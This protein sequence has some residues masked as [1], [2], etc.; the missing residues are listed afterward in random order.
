MSKMR[1]SHYKRSLLTPPL[2]AVWLSEETVRQRLPIGTHPTSPTFWFTLRCLWPATTLMGKALQVEPRKAKEG[3]HGPPP[4]EA[5]SPEE[6]TMSRAAVLC[7]RKGG[8]FHQTNLV[9]TSAPPLN[10]PTL[11]SNSATRTCL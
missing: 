1:F 10:S 7:C 5:Y 11:L 3:N 9:F 4:G 2:L 8:D 6:D